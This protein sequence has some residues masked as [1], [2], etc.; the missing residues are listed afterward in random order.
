MNQLAEIDGKNMW[1]MISEDAET[2]RKELVYNIDE[3]YNYAA[4]R[5]G[6]WKYIT[7]TPTTQNL[8]YG[9]S[10]KNN[11]DYKYDISAVLK[12]ETATT[13]AGMLTYQQIAAKNNENSTKIQL[14][15]TETILRLRRNAEIHCASPGNLTE[16]QKCKP[17]E[18]PCVFNLKDDPCEQINLAQA[19]PDVLNTLQKLVETYRKTAVKPNNIPR[20]PKADPAFY[21]NTW[22]NWRDWDDEVQKQRISTKNLSPLAIGLISAACFAVLLAVIVLVGVRVKRVAPKSSRSFS[23]SGDECGTMD[24]ASVEM[25]PKVQMFEDRELQQMR[26]SFKDC[27]KSVE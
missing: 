2:P 9:N 7:G 4:V 6:D 1:P 23:L 24:P 10:G 21:N 11:T 5:K 12:S 13:L 20:D 27:R 22:T 25:A 8:W 3:I 15:A 16:T 19:H 17:L 26:S 14:L 18:S